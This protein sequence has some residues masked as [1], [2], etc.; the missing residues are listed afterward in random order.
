VELLADEAA[1]WPSRL[2][3]RGFVYDSLFE[4]PP[5][6]VTTRL[7]WLRHNEG[8]GYQPQPYEQLAAVY[9]R[10]GREHDA[11]KVAIAKRRHRRET[12]TRPGRVWDRVLDWTVAYGYR[13]W[14]AGIWLLLLVII[15][16]AV[17]S[18]AHPEQLTDV[19]PA[20]GGSIPAFQPWTYALDVLLPI[21][22]LRQ[23]EFR[24]PQGAARW[25]AWFSIVSG[26][27]LVT[28]VLA[29]VTGIL[30]KE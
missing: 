22:N 16:A 25:W 7:L 21:V 4:D 13:T 18:M 3:L 20:A 17:F 23:E 6:D 15:G 10:S 5:I 1:T 26:W 11:R 8:G 29:A 14:Q 30:R 9:R 19:K 27:I 24:I 12:L 2:R 28:I